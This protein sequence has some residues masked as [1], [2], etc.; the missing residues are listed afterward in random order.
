MI[1]IKEFEND[2]KKKGTNPFNS[3]PYSHKYYDLLEKRKVLPAWEA[4]EHLITLLDEYQ[5]LILQGE[6]GSGKTTQIPQ[7]LANSKFVQKYYL[8]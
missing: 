6:T 2:N 8:F 7:F 4:R 1:D 3:M 5:V